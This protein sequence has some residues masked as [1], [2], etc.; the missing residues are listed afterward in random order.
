LLP[1]WLKGFWTEV[2]FKSKKNP[3]SNNIFEKRTEFILA[4]MR[5][6][7]DE[8]DRRVLFG[9]KADRVVVM[10]RPIGF[11]FLGLDFNCTRL[12]KHKIDHTH[13]RF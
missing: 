10:L 6:P 3:G 4:E 13:T 2:I 11:Q 7:R 8:G 5:D 12:Y 9:D 1:S